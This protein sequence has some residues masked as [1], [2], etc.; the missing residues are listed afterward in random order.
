M[1]ELD[2]DLPLDALVKKHHSENNNGNNEKVI[3]LADPD[4]TVRVSASFFW[5]SFELQL[6]SKITQITVAV[7]SESESSESGTSRSEP[8]AQTLM[9]EILA[10]KKRKEDEYRIE[11][12]AQMK[13]SDKKKSGRRG[14]FVL[15]KGNVS[16]FIAFIA[17]V[18]RL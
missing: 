12:L 5:T 2:D 9:Q 18:H 15:R 10:E 3:P 8:A 14:S 1:E 13:K 17:V 11:K 16:C 4:G 7:D 6:D